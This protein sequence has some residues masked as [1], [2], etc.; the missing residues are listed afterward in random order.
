MIPSHQLAQW[1]LSHIDRFLNWAGLSHNH[2]LESI[3]YIAIIVVIAMVIAWA[4]RKAVLFVV[5]K[6]VAVRHSTIGDELLKQ[7]TL[8]RCS[9][10]ITPLVLLGLLP[11]AFDGA[12]KWSV[13]ID[14]VVLI[15][16]IVMFGVAFSSVLSFVWTHYDLHENTK[17][18]PL[19]G[20]LNIAKGVVWGIVVIVAVS[21]LV[22]K[23]PAVLLTGLGAF[24]AALMPIFKDSILGFV[25][26]IQLSQNDMLRVGD[27]IVVPSTIAN[28]IVT[29]VTLSV[30]KVLN[31][32]YTTVMLPPY[33][34]VSTSFQNWRSM[35]DAGC[36]NIGRSMLVDADS[37]KM[38][39]ADD[40]K[41]WSEKLPIL[42]DYI[43]KM[44]AVKAKD[45]TQ[46]II[47]GGDIK[48]NGSIE[49]NLGVFRAYCVL[50]L[51]QCR[52]IAQDQL[53][54]VR[55]MTP[56]ASGIPVQIWCFTN[57]TAWDHYES[58]QSMI[59]ENFMAA[60]SIFGITIY[61]Y[62]STIAVTDEPEPAPA[63]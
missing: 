27:W 30:V 32:D 26:G 59:F 8:S 39:S 51:Q 7:H 9:H 12:S 29:D 36:R 14:R 50:Y 44:T 20:I 63:H 15:Y 31:W 21:V 40:L 43:T 13:V 54:M 47:A 1:L 58:I 17:K 41:A 28:G 5:R 24:A 45:G 57:D 23:S 33:T 52:H 62:P 19:K 22:D 25:A 48:A 2:S 34:L 56:E 37:I 10:V 4:V 55:M 60:A 46:Q 38:A 3:M 11:F 35:S 16:A 49:T 18:L 6:A 53:I 61:N 42:A